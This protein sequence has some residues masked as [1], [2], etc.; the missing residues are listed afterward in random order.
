MDGMNH[1]SDAVMDPQITGLSTPYPDLP[2]QQDVDDFL[3]KK[4]K[5]REHKACYP[6]RQRKVKY[7]KSLFECILRTLSY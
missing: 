7:V 4:R 2:P 5:A 6:C 3:R 1:P